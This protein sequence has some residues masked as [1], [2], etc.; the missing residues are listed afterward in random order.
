MPSDAR[1]TPALQAMAQP[2]AE[3]R[4]II[5][6]ALA[7]AEHFLVA[8]GAGEPERAARAARELGRFAAGRI[9]PAR[10][11]TLFPAVTPVDA[12]A[13]TALTRAIAE[14]RSTASRGDEAF[15]IELPRGGRLDARVGDA[16]AEIGRAFGA[17]ILADVVRSGRYQPGEHAHLLEPLAFHAW[18]R[19]ERRYAPPLIVSV[20]G[21]DLHVGAL[22]DF[23]DGRA[24]LVLVVRGPAAPAPLV[25]CITPGTMVL[26]T[27]DGSGL[28]RVAAFDG[29]AVA[30]LMPEGSA[31]FLHDPLAGREAWQR[32]TVRTQGEVPKRAIGGIS[33][34][35]M[36]EDRTLLGDLARTP[37]AIP[38][39]GGSAAPALGAEDA[40]D[41][42]A[43]W[44][45]SQSVPQ[46][47]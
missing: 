42:I 39:A 33:V 20:D 37:F 31:V 26:Q 18:G 13:L 2:I 34:W 44:L 24:R 3:F 16:F 14:L 35:Q 32:L 1:F 29:P 8:Q 17:V 9:D 36:T 4:A 47:S 23:A 19:A 5:Q 41:R 46:G 38:V 7:Q 28:D 11:A 43:A 27:T 21:A 45:L 22:S 30:A 10:F 6:G 12:G 25:R 40:V 15:V